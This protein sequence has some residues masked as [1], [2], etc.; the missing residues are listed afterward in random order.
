MRKTLCTIVVLAVVASASASVQIFF[1]NGG[2]Y[3]WLGPGPIYGPLAPTGGHGQDYSEDGYVPDFGAFPGEFV[4]SATARVGGTVYIWLRFNNEPDR[5]KLQGLDLVLGG[6]PADVAY[7]ICLDPAAYKRWDGSCASPDCPAFKGNPRQILVAITSYGIRNDAF[8]MPP[9]LYEDGAARTALLGAVKY[10]QPGVYTP[11][12]G[13]GGISYQNHP[14]P[15]VEFGS[16]TI[17]LPACRGDTNC[18]G[19][20]DFNDI[21]P[22]VAALSGGA[23][24]DGTGYNCDINGDGQVD[25]NDIDPFVALLTTGATCP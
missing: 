13:P 18:D 12:L 17:T 10:E 8:D 16:L 5:A 1:T 15:T 20:I 19:N 21:D 4:P 2:T 6:S 23:C 24:C 3:P 14:P 11:R 25:F 7:Y 9:N 22:F